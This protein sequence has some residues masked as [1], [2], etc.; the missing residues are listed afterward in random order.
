MEWTSFLIGAIPSLVALLTIIIQV[1]RDK[2][3][4]AAEVNKIRSERLLNEAQ[5]ADTITDAAKKVV[6]EYE[7]LMALQE[8]RHEFEIQEKQ[9]EIDELR[10]NM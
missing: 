6:A 10:N 1:I 5:T 7:K 3:K 2:Q 8:K 9:E 4:N